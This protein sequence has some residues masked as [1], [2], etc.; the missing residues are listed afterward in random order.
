MSILDVTQLVWGWRGLTRLSLNPSPTQLRNPLLT[1]QV[2]EPI[3]IYCPNLYYLGLHLDCRRRAV[4]DLQ[5]LWHV[6][7]FLR[8]TSLNVGISQI[9]V[10]E[11]H[12][13]ASVYIAYMCPD[14]QIVYTDIP[15]RGQ[16]H[17]LRSTVPAFDQHPLDHTRISLLEDAA[18]TRSENWNMNSR[19]ISRLNTP[20]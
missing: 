16:L 8:L 11:W 1:L 19:L 6:N 3:A 14:I 13:S 5:P 4:A 2:L 9:V 15:W 7:P 20:L 10:S 18:T 17:L 12:I